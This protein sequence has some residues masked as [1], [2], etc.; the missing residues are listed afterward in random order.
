MERTTDKWMQKF[1]DTLVPETFVEITVG[2]TA[3]GVNK[4]AKFVTSAMSAFASANALSQAGVA[5]F[6]KY[7]TGEP[8]L[9]VLDGS[10]KVVPA[11]APYENTG[12]VSS[13][14]FSTSNHPVLLP[15]FSMR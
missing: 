15:C 5:S 10:C 8:N 11:S 7:G 2:I 12:F 1:N 13:T 4:K 9:C 3:P 14:I 6:T